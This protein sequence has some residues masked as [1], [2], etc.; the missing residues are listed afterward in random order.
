M[1][2]FTVIMIADQIRVPMW[3]DEY[4]F[5]R[6]T[7]ELPST[8][9]T[10]DWFYK[11]NPK[12]L[13]PSDVW[14]TLG[15][16][17][18]RP[19]I[20]ALTYNT[21][22]YV[23]I[24]L[25][26]YL[27]WPLVKVMDTLADKGI[28]AHIEDNQDRNQNIEVMTMVFRLVPIGL[29]LASMWLIYLILSRRIGKYALFM[30]IPIMASMRL[31][32]GIPY[33]YWDC[34]MLFFF[35]LTFYL[36]ERGSKWAYLTACLMVN[37]KITIG[38]LLLIP[39]IIRDRKMILP[40]FSLIIYYIGTIIVTHDWLWIFRHLLSTTSNYAYTYVFWNNR[41]ILNLGLFFCALFT[42]PIFWY[43]KKYPQFV[44]GWIL[45]FIYAWGV[46]LAIDKMSAMLY[47]S[48]LVFP[49]I[50]YEFKIAPYMN[51]WLDKAKVPAVK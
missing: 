37:T 33:F 23:H 28:I 18:D 3:Q 20:F 9:T 26:N 7:K 29:F 30:V 5:Y 38:L 11:D 47:G 41:L 13:Y 6:I 17:L 27:M 10:S 19:K 4:V 42:I 25:A 14:D 32:D 51:K 44:A 2:L 34:F 8:A 31:L 12:T 1:G 50:A 15:V 24:P 22:M 35:V 46:G 21:P 36:Q 45:T 16:H 40:A 43:I 49:F 39:F 48:A